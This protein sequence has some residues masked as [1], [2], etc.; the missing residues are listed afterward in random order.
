MNWHKTWQVD[1]DPKSR[2]TL[3][4]KVLK[5]TIT[6][7]CVPQTRGGVQPGTEVTRGR[8]APE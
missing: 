4:R 2:A 5:G 7:A 8:T 6:P 1:S 3:I